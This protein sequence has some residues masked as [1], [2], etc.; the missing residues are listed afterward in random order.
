M[1]TNFEETVGSCRRKPRPEYV[2]FSDS[3]G[4]HC[5]EQYKYKY[6]FLK[7]FIVIYF[8]RNK[9]DTKSQHK[10]LSSST[11]TIE[12]REGNVK[13]LYERLGGEEA[14]DAVVKRFY[15]KVLADERINGMFKN[16]NM[17]RQHRM[18]KAFL[19]HAFGG[20]SYNGKNMRQAHK[21]LGITDLHFNAVAE[22]VLSTLKVTLRLFSFFVLSFR[23]LF[24]FVLIFVFRYSFSFPF[25]FRFRSRFLILFSC[26]LGV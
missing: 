24:I 10:M 5:K 19:S 7:T 22:H 16:T 3:A 17:S 18:Q 26:N 4:R 14:M 23:F 12:P 20:P 8:T 1:R 13:T 6:A 11:T 15:E 25:L 21:R 9:T 2:E